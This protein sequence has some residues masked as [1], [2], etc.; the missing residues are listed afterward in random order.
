MKRILTTP[1]L[2]LLKIC[3]FLYFKNDFNLLMLKII[4]KKNILIY[5]KLK[6]TFKKKLLYFQ[7]CLKMDD[8]A[9]HP[10]FLNEP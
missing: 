6:N 3:L 1:N 9:M 8:T 5:F 7:T 2:F 10:I 4:I